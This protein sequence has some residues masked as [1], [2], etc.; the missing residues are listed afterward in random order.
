MELHFE[1]EA[2]DVFTFG[3]L[4]LR[5]FLHCQAVRKKIKLHEG[6]YSYFDVGLEF[7]R[8]FPEH[9]DDAEDV[10]QVASRIL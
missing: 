1:K 6:L 2:V 7:R 3:P 9:E 5:H 4:A 8:T 10:E